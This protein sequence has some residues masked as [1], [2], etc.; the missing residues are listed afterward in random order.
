MDGDEKNEACQAIQNSVRLSYL[1]NWDTGIHPQ[2]LTTDVDC[3]RVLFPYT[4]KDSGTSSGEQGQNMV[5]T[6]KGKGETHAHETGNIPA[7]SWHQSD[8]EGLEGHNDVPLLYSAGKDSALLHVD[9][10]QGCHLLGDTALERE[11]DTNDAHIASQGNDDNDGIPESYISNDSL[12]LV[13]LDNFASPSRV[14]KILFP[15]DEKP[16]EKDKG[17]LCY[18]PPRFPSADIP[19]FSCD[20]VPSNSDLRQEYSPFGI[21]QLMNRTTPLRLWD[22]P[23]NDKSPDVMLKDAAKSFSGAPSI[24]KKR[25]RDLLYEYSDNKN[26]CASSEAK[27]DPKETLESSAKTVS[28]SFYSTCIIR[29]TYI[30][31]TSSLLDQETRK[32]LVYYNDAEMQLSSPD[33]TGSIP[34]N[35]VNTVGKDPF[36]GDSIPLS[37]ITENKTNTA[38][39]SFDIIE[40]YSM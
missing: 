34:D 11:T 26:K 17:S 10:I 6:P 39:S 27:E 37:A 1:P 29:Y 16:A 20:L 36:T 35:K 28:P 19:F 24:L 40:N 9:S 38:E 5:D 25:H 13:P 2:P 18:E 22:S 21:R 15:I 14:N 30:E 8:S 32:S 3:C 7:L 4:M 23:R 33:K 31:S 12:K